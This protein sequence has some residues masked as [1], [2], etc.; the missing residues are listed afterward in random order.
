VRGLENQEHESRRDAWRGEQGGPAIPQGVMGTLLRCRRRKERHRRIVSLAI[1]PVVAV[2][3][4]VVLVRAFQRPGQPA[5]PAPPDI[6][7]DVHGWIAFG[8]A[9]GS[10]MG[11]V[12][13]DPGSPNHH[14]KLTA[15]GGE[16]VAWSQDGSKLL[17][18]RWGRRGDRRVGLFVLNADGSETRVTRDGFDTGGSF[19]P[20]GSQVVYAR[21]IFS[22]P[23]PWGI[24]VVDSSGGT[25]RLI[26]KDPDAGRAPSILRAPV[27]SPDGTRIAY[28]GG[29]GD[30][31]LSLWLMTADGTDRRVLLDDD[32]PPLKGFVGWIYHLDWSPDGTRLAFELR[33]GPHNRIYVVGVDGTGLTLVARDGLNPHW[34]PDGS[35]LSFDRTVT[36]GTARLW[37]SITDPD[38][39][40][41]QEVRSAGSGPWNPVQGKTAMAPWTTLLLVGIA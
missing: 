15:H 11:I 36:D 13:V 27:F 33:G 10:G 31:S 5:R 1:G 16:P 7:S 25:P 37:L 8:E 38:G 4:L 14:V 39:T 18:R 12:A 41:E 29:S 23:G 26:A 6:F 34:S 28:V 17:F 3:S 2:V 22:R 32:Q 21:D 9:D 40:H 24:Y 30:N 19:S 20:D 35:R